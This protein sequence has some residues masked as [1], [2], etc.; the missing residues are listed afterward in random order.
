MDVVYAPSIKRV[1]LAAHAHARA[2]RTDP[3]F[4]RYR[5]WPDPE[6]QLVVEHLHLPYGY[7]FAIL[8][9]FQD[10]PSHAAERRLL[11][12]LLLIADSVTPFGLPPSHIEQLSA[13]L[14]TEEEFELFSRLPS[15]LNRESYYSRWLAAAGI[16][17]QFADSQ[18]L[19]AAALGGDPASTLSAAPFEIGETTDRTH[20]Q[21][22]GEALVPNVDR[23]WTGRKQADLFVSSDERL[24][25][26]FLANQTKL[27]PNNVLGMLATAGVVHTVPSISCL[28]W[29]TVLSLREKLV[30]ERTVYVT[31]LR[32]YLGDCVDGLKS[33]EFK[34]VFS[35]AE[36][37]TSQHLQ[38]QVEEIE[39][40][41][42]KLDRKLL[43]RVRIGAVDGIPS[44]MSALKEKSLAAAGAEAGSQLLRILCTSL[45][46]TWE[47]R[48][49][50]REH[51]F[52]SFVY[53]LR[54]DTNSEEGA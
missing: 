2:L 16:L 46:R 49:Q 47:E 15:A 17:D 50:L 42:K 45:T 12:A 13:N 21:G 19:S 53:A 24:S 32:K 3:D 22:L 30:E 35:W 29:E 6:R 33:Q 7:K 18:T 1:L 26:L 23:L 37:H 38:M 39:N 8:D 25:F 44:I 28:D 4:K 10:S 52:A 34:E 14:P 5:E 9:V 36:W 40:Q 31:S 54:R 43:D 51:P 27:T 20:I 48:K 11:T 41:T